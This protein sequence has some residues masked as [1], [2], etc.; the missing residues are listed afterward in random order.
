MSRTDAILQEIQKLLTLRRRE[1]DSASDLAE[2]TL[3]VKLQAGTTW[4]RGTQYS[5][6]RV[7]RSRDNRQPHHVAGGGS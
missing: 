5:E 7:V 1:L 2:V 3:T 6:E 4:V